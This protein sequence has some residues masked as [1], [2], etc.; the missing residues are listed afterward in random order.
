MDACYRSA[1]SGRWE[2]VELFEWR[3]LPAD[4]APRPE[5]PPAAVRTDDGFILVKSER[6]P[7]GTVKRILRDPST[8]EI[9]QRTE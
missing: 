2:P 7:D 1:A 5:G 9:F 4:A 8:G 6:M 3:G